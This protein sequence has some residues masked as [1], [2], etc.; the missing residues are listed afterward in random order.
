MSEQEI[1]QRKLAKFLVDDVFN[2]IS[3][4]NI[5]EFKNGEYW[6][7]GNPITKG[8]IEI[9]KKEAKQISKMGTYNILMDEVRYHARKA[10]EKAETEQDIITAKLLSYFVD[11]IKS[12]LSK[13]SEL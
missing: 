6:H 5:L 1:L 10:L 7:K 11:V 12:K 9:I 8:Q 2:T 4:D 13:L 3:S